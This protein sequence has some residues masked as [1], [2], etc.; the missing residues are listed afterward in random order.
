M[1]KALV[2]IAAAVM[3]TTLVIAIVPVFANPDVYEVPTYIFVDLKAM[4][5][6]D[7][8]VV[9]GQPTIFYLWS[10]FGPPVNLCDGVGVIIKGGVLTIFGRCITIS[11]YVDINAGK[12][13]LSGGGKLTGPVVL[14]L[15]VAGRPPTVMKF[16]MRPGCIICPQTDRTLAPTLFFF[17]RVSRHR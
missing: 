4:V 5:Q 12:G 8:Y 11:P 13:V 16:I 9:A 1:R 3:L 7:I 6:L 10:P 17:F 15:A 2:G 14:V